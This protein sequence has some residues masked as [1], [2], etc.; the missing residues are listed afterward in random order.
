MEKQLKV[1]DD[2][3]KGPTAVSVNLSLEKEH[4]KELITITEEVSDINS[5][6]NLVQLSL[7]QLQD[8][9]IIMLVAPISRAFFIPACHLAPRGLFG[10]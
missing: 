2:V 7:N 6:V 9:S 1:Q 5:K 10:C 4:P 8:P 3:L